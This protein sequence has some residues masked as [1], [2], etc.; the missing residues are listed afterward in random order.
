MVEVVA[1]YA[2][3]DWSL[4]NAEQASDPN[5]L[6]TVHTMTQLPRWHPITAR[7]RSDEIEF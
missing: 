6:F 2:I 7:G 5:L 1:R 4:S 3:G